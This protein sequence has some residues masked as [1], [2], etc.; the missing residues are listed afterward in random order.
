[1]N[2]KPSVSDSSKAG[3]THNGAGN[4]GQYV[5]QVFM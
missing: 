3:T 4:V 1:M 2:E 5:P